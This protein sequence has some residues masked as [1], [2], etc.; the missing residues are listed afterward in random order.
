MQ[1]QV[2]IVDVQLESQSVTATAYGD[3]FNLSYTIPE[4]YS[5][6][7]GMYFNPAVSALITLRSQ[8]AQKNIL[9]GFNTGIGTFGWIEL[10]NKALANDILNM[11]I[12]IVVNPFGGAPAF[13]FPLT[14]TLAYK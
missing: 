1:Q 3:K 7:A 14:F 13:P 8:R 12:E 11:S 2:G 5:R 10:M 4:N 6:V 9:T